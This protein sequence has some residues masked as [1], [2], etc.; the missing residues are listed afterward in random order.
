MY[1]KNFENCCDRYNSSDNIGYVIYNLCA[2]YL[3]EQFL[4]I[5][6]EQ[7]IMQIKLKNLA[8]WISVQI[9]SKRSTRKSCL[10]G[11]KV[12]INV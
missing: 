8:P 4:M 2:Q 7:Q 1:Y 3:N 12:C 5:S 10:N 6:R 11:Y 9:Q